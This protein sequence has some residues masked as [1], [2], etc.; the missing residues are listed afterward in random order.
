M[1]R[2]GQTARMVTVGFL[3]TSAVHVPVFESLVAA[4]D[5]SVQVVDVVDPSLLEQA[6]RVGAADADVIAGVTQAIGAL[7]ASGAD[8][9]VCT[10]STIGAVAET[11]GRQAGIDV[12]RV[13]RAMAQRAVAAG[14]R[15]VVL[16]AVASTIEPTVEL[17][18]AVAASMGST[19]ELDIRLVEGA[20]AR[21]E[22]GD[23]P[24]Y[25]A[26]IAEAIEL[27]GDEDVI[28]LAQASMAPAAD[29]VDVRADVLSSPGPAVERLLAASRDGCAE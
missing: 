1:R 7:V 8:R 28:V 19:P 24:S 11:I 16:A 2:A 10:C 15:V 26:L 27:A 4:A 20:W 18:E 22:A 12:A 5:P 6:Q 14:S 25:Q 3:H 9:V 13:D 29:L 23:L 21:F 17:L